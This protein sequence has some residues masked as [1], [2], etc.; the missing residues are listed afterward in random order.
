MTLVLKKCAQIGMLH[1]NAMMWYEYLGAFIHGA[2]SATGLLKAADSF[3]RRSNRPFS[4]PR[5]SAG[6]AHY[7]AM[8]VY[9]E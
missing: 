2:S 7:H 4:F 8:E 3:L 5:N 1:K 9:A 6:C